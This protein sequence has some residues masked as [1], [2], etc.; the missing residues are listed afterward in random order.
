MID[1]AVILAAGRG[2]RL[3]PSGQ[4]DPFSKPLIK[5]AGRSLL[6]RTVEQC[7]KAGIKELWVVTGYQQ[8]KLEHEIATF[9]NGDIKTVY[10]PNWHLSNGVSLLSCSTF[11]DRPFSLM[12]CDHIFDV[13][14]LADLVRYSLPKDAV[15]LACDFKIDTIFD[16]DDAT[17]VVVKENNIAKISKN[18][19]EFNA[20]DC[21][22]FVCSPT[23]FEVLHA[24]YNE[25]GDCSLSEGMH[26]MAKNQQ[27]LAFDIKGRWW[28]DVDTPDMLEEA[29]KLLSLNHSN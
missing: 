15:A 13:T 27:F 20:V 6:E 19:K 29:T 9:N 26:Q 25:Q 3:Q 10:N 5:L 14:I 8:E 12:M 11:I 17:K 24:L 1:I 7:R 23:I 21:G 2:S 4:S 28:Q 16:I 22:L 18:L